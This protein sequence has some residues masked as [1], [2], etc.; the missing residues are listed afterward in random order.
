MS[1]NADFI[2]LEDGTLP[3]MFNA[4]PFQVFEGTPLTIDATTGQLRPAADNESVYGLS[5]IDSNMYR[6][7]SFGEAGAFGSGALTVLLLGKVELSDSV[8]NKVEVNSAS[9]NVV[10]LT[11]SAV[12][13]PVFDHSKTYVPMQSLYVKNGLISNDNS[14]GGPAI[15]KVLAP[16]AASAEGPLVMSLN[17]PA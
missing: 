10:P 5:K 7:L 15:G 14:G 4:S 9:E 8:Y 11:S 3:K 13:V 2:V 12:T 16:L 17:C 6:D 1:I